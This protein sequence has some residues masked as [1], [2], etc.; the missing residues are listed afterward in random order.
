MVWIS[1]GIGQRNVKPAFMSAFNDMLVRNDGWNVNAF[2]I[3]ESVEEARP[4]P[5]GAC[6]SFDFY[7]NRA[8][9]SCSETDS[10]CGIA[11]LTWS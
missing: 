5:F 8:V 6:R 3:C 2:L 9:A 10:G 4:C 7:A 11:V 1:F